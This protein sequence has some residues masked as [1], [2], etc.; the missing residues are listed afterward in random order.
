MRDASKLDALARTS[1]LLVS[2]LGVIAV[3]PAPLYAQDPDV[4]VLTWGYD[5]YKT[6]QNLDE[7]VLTSSSISSSGQNF[8]QLC[9]IQLDG[10]VYAQPLAVAGKVSDVQ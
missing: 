6:E 9:N 8:G 4:N 5:A 2:V 1:A 3:A 7:S 10:Q